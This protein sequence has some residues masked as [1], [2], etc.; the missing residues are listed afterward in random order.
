MSLKPDPIPP[1]P[2]ETA[3][4]ARAAFPHGNMY[5]QLRDLLGSIYVDV[6]FADLFSSRGQ[7]AAAPWRLALVTIF[8]FLENLSDRQAADAVRG[9]LD[10]KYALSL[11]LTDA[12]W[13]ASVLSEF[14]T[15]LVAGHAEM[16]LLDHLL[17]LC[18]EHGWL[19]ERGRQR[20]DST[21]VLAKVRALNRVLCVAQ[22]MV[23]VLNVLAEVAPD[24][25][26]THCPAEDTPAWL[27]T[28]PAVAMLHQVWEQQYLPQS[29][30]GAWR[31]RE[32]ALPASQMINTPYD[33]DARYAVKNQTSWV[34]YKVHLSESCEEDAPHLL[35]QVY[36][37]PAGIN[38]DTALPTIHAQM[39]ARHQLPS[40]HLV[41]SGYVDARS[42]VQS[43]T[44]YA[45][46]VIGPTKGN[47]WWQAE[48]GYDLTQF[49][50]DWS[51]QQVYCPEQHVSSS[52][53]PAHDSKGR[54]VIKIKFS[55]SDCKPC[56]HRPECT[57][58]T[59]RTLTLR[60]QEQM[61]ALLAARQ[62]EQ[63]AA[64]REIY[65][66]RAGIEGT[67]SQATRAMGL[68]RSRYIG[69]QKT[70]LG[71]VATATAINLLRIV[72]WERGILPCQTRTSPLR[73]A[74]ALVA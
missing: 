57:G 8:Q 60:P 7:P 64:F 55:Q 50:I 19:K 11:P 67:H 22:T 54:D 37:T 42:L 34:G 31:S 41:D 66:Q 32:Q 28:L 68:R 25:V 21:H 2:T 73:A 26:Q 17:D 45:I 9:Q 6:E 29:A 14:R 65:H 49:M 61:E 52:W 16:R 63:T 70:H 46:A 69:G 40:E 4:V 23:Y 56:P 44:Q 27:Q 62:R 35:T 43:Q 30:G 59:R 48:T 10:W 13:D 58:Q 1:V 74:F 39:A 36:T 12:G 33:P 71:H 38:D 18:R 24:W 53:T 15:R 5:L 3:L 72:S 47:Y 20:T 51:T